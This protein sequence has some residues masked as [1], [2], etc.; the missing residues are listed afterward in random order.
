MFVV[1]GKVKGRLLQPED[2]MTER[3]CVNI[4]WESTEQN[5]NQTS[6][7]LDGAATKSD[8]SSG[9]QGQHTQQTTQQGI[10]QGPDDGN[11]F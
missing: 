4:I 3:N 5:A 7:K 8:F 11:D 9:R 6:V 2:G 10:G 1:P